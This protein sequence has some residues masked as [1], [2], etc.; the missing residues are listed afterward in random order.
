MVE[1]QRRVRW[2]T[3]QRGA[4]HSRWFGGLRLYLICTAAGMPVLWA[5]ADPKIGEREVRP[6]C[7]TSSRS[8]PSAGPGLTLITG[9]GFASGITLLRPARKDESARH[10]EPL[11]RSVRQM[12][13][14]RADPSKALHSAPF[15]PPDLRQPFA[16]VRSCLAGTPASS[17]AIQLAGGA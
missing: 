2:L 10:G 16:G 6:G 9:K 11:L 13:E 7:S 17:P 3:R 5:L 15:G 12:I 8:S 4:S 1:L 14:S